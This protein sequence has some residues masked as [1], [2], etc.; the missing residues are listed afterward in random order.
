MSIILK[1]GESINM[2]GVDE[3]SH[4]KIREIVKSQGLC[5]VTDKYGLFRHYESDGWNVL[6]FDEDG[7]LCWFY[8]K[9]T[10]NPTYHWKEFLEA[11]TMKKEF[12]KA[13][14]KTGMKVV[15]RSGDEGIVMKGF[16]SNDFGGDVIIYMDGGWD[17]LSEY[18]DDLS[19]KYPALDIMSVFLAERPRQL[20]TSK[21]KFKLLWNREE[22]TEQQKKI[23]ELEVTIKKAQEQIQEL[24]GIQK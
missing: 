11:N 4:N 19:D 13:D 6:V 15:L 24:K 2:R 7:D 14:L 22:K 18:S 16:I 5:N 8:P 21:G 3:E 23:E 9:S 1:Q 12:T 17:R 10:P 20:L